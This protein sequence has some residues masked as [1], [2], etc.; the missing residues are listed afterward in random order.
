MNFISQ[1]KLII[2]ILAITLAKGIIW[3]YSTP[4]FQAPDEQVHYASIQYYAEPAGFEPKSYDFP[5]GKTDMFNLRT[6]N[7]S[8]ELKNFLDRTQFDKVR[9]HKEKIMDFH[10]GSMDGNYEKDIR[11]NTLG[12]FVE[13][14]PAWVTNYSSPYYQTVAGI[15]N[16]F[17]GRS[18]IERVFL[19]RL[20]SV[21]LLTIF[22]LFS[23][24]TFRE[25][26]QGET[27]SA[28][29][30]GA[31]SFQPM[32]TFITSSIN[33]DAFLIAAFGV[34]LYGAVRFLGRG[35]D[36]VSVSC[37]L[38]GA[39]V[40]FFSKP[41]GYFA[42][43]VVLFL[44]IL[45][46]L[47]RA[48]R[49]LKMDFRAKIIIQ[50][51]FLI[52]VIALGWLISH[53]YQTVKSRYFPGSQPLHIL[54]DYIWH[55]ISPSVLYAHSTYYWGN[56]GWL[57]TPFPQYLIYAI[58]VVI[59]LALGGIIW[60]VTRNIYHWSALKQEEKFLFYQLIFLIFVV[61][62]FSFMIHAVNFQMVNPNN[63]ADETNA[64][65]IQGRY[66][67]PVMGAKFFLIFWGIAYI[68]NAIVGE[69]LS[70][71]SASAGKHGAFLRKA[72]AE[73]TALAL[74]IGILLLNFIGLFVYLIPRFY[75]GEG[76]VFISQELL[77]R[78]SQY[79]PVLLKDWIII[80]VFIF[81][82]VLI[83]KLFVSV[84]LTPSSEHSRDMT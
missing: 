58:W 37:L 82:L 35:A 74:F 83:L 11:Q 32:I 43:A 56:F 5:I 41:P 12:R 76:A 60:S 10:T 80:F 52:F 68:L 63:V 17:S 79:K 49:Y 21:I 2:L 25:L 42:L 28:L 67:F 36:S 44:L 66:F 46:F 73:M 81:Y 40:S 72:K 75:L 61:L 59:A 7:L 62:G 27:V 22:V 33:I 77:D 78:M 13:Q 1:N 34:L 65:A 45:F 3:S 23:Y 53:L 30:A 14:Y 16:L 18:I 38:G 20:F 57:D 8:P 39:I 9:F 26:A 50:S 24:L 64:I 19:G 69:R 55:Q 29:L 51:G 4:L 54:D 71:A 47:S 48:R 15:E 6:Q 31:I 84:K 70:Y